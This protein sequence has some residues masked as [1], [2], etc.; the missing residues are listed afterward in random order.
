[1]ASIKVQVSLRLDP[2]I[3]CKM[4]KLCT[5][6]HRSLNNMIE[7]VLIDK[8]K[9]HEKENGEIVITDEELYLE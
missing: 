3:Y 2:L 8:I 5:D 6:E 9:S 7:A 4:K 1:M